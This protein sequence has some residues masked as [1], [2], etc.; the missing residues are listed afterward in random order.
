MDHGLQDST[1]ALAE[2]VLDS[3]LDSG[4]L[5]DIPIIGT[6]LA[7]T[8]ATLVIRD[9]LFLNKLLHFLK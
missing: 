5:K 8:R 9:R 4:V 1:A 7:L 3:T 6:A 2:V